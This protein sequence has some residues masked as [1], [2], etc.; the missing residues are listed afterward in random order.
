MP[1]LS[2]EPIPVL[3]YHSVADA[4]PPGQEQLYT[5]APKRFGEH[6]AL[7][8]NAGFTAVTVSALALALKGEAPFPPRPIALTFDD[9]FDDTLSAVETLKARGIPAT[10]YVTSGTVA[11][12]AGIS[13]GALRALAQGD[14]EIGAHSV[15]HPHLD[16]LPQADA[17]REIKD[18][19]HQ[20]EQQLERSITTFAYPHGAYDRGVRES[21]IAAGFSSAV[22]V[23]NA[24][25]HRA[26]DP[27]AIARWT[28]TH[29][30]S[31]ATL[32]RVLSGDGAPLAWSRERHR[33]RASRAARRLRR[34]IRAGRDGPATT[35]GSSA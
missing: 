4:P 8:A 18:S 35:G 34:R 15:S 17:A 27:F 24:L 9:G 26:D 32:E 33:T 11:T 30:T 25:S 3:L 31:V 10:V 5:V 12:P 21:V 29:D 19:R 6:V 7:I 28:V 20:L 23:K 2:Q 22:A 13:L 1:K 14:C 16:E